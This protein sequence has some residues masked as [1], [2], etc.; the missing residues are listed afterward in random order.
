MDICILYFLRKDPTGRTARQ[1]DS[2]NLYNLKNI[3]LTKC[4]KSLKLNFSQ[5]W[6]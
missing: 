3:H 5:C 6:K 2:L 4:L 1:S